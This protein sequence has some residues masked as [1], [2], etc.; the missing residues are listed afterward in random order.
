MTATPQP[1]IA[2]LRELLKARIDTLDRAA[3]LALTAALSPEDADADEAPATSPAVMTD[4]EWEAAIEAGLEEMRAGRVVPL[5]DHV[6]KL[7]KYE[8]H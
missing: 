6:V 5:A 4:A 3:L 2:E 1:T 8:V 7:R